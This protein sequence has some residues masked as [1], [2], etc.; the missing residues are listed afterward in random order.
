VLRNHGTMKVGAD[1]KRTKSLI[2]LRFPVER[3]KVVYD[4]SVN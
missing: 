2:S 4:Q 1:E 3:R